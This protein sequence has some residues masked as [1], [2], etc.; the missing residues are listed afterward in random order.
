M[1]EVG[2]TPEL[3]FSIS[4]AILLLNLSIGYI[5]NG[6]FR[7]E[8]GGYMQISLFQ[9]GGG[10]HPYFNQLSYV[11]YRFNCT[12]HFNQYLHYKKLNF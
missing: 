9:L 3:T 6:M 4:G 10:T 2:S 12:G 5:P 1:K 8:F 7:I 11:N